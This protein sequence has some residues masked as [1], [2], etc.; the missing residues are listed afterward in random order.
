MP[1]VVVN[2]NGT[3]TVFP[4]GATT[5]AGGNSVSITNTLSKPLTVTHGGNLLADN[6]FTVP[7]HGSGGPPKVVKQL[8]AQADT[9]GTVFRITI[10][11]SRVG[12]PTIII[13]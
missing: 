13:L 2:F 5:A 1:F 9:S 8:T 4:P 10:E 3:E 12:D 6:P 7:A 11:A